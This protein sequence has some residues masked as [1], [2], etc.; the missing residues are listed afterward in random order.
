MLQDKVKQALDAD[1][2][3]D[4]MRAVE[5]AR[6]KVGPAFDAD[7]ADMWQLGLALPSGISFLR[8]RDGEMHI[9]AGV[10]DASH[11]PASL[12]EEGSL[13]RL[14]HPFVQFMQTISSTV[15]KLNITE[16]KLDYNR[17]LR[18]VT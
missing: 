3:T 15:Y 14:S 13:Q 6:V 16:L 17:H 8:S 18:K 11:H 7:L 10:L 12:D 9:Q 1:K 2:F 5:E 4:V